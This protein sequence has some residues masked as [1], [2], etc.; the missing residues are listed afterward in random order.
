MPTKIKVYTNSLCSMMPL[1]TLFFLVWMTEKNTNRKR[2]LST[3]VDSDHVK[4]P[5]MS[6]S[7]F[8]SHC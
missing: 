6:R 4:V 5:R 8:T 2:P 1:A 3:N 7:Y